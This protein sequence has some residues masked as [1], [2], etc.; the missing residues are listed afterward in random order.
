[1]VCWFNMLSDRIRQ[2]EKRRQAEGDNGSSFGQCFCTMSSHAETGSARRADQRRRRAMA[3]RLVVRSAARDDAVKA[4][5][6]PFHVQVGSS[7]YQSTICCSDR[8][9]CKRKA[10]RNHFEMKRQLSPGEGERERERERE[11]N[12]ERVTQSNGS[13]VDLQA[14][15]FRR[16]PAPTRMQ[17]HFRNN[18]RK[19]KTK[20][21]LKPEVTVRYFCRRF[22]KA[23]REA[24]SI[25]RARQNKMSI[26]VDEHRGKGSKCKSQGHQQ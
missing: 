18:S 3:R 10:S 19:Q 23:S 1:L 16:S 25:K 5:F 7:I 26:Q 8:R 2:D 14:K 13:N 15:H 17:E 9:K 12:T 4:M 20:S 6:R 21:R 11:S 24:S 22:E